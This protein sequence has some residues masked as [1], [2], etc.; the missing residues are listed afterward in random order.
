MNDTSN[1]RFVKLDG[2]GDGLN[3]NAPRETEG[4]SIIEEMYD[5]EQTVNIDYWC[6]SFRINDTTT[7]RPVTLLMRRMTVS[8]STSLITACRYSGS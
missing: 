6:H 7:I 8:S 1:L 3:D 2:L 4:G 5:R